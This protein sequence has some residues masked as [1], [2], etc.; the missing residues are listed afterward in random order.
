MAMVGID[1][2]DMPHM[3]IFYRCLG[4]DR[5]SVHWC[6]TFTDS[7]GHSARKSSELLKMDF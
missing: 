1:L 2:Y 3:T 6:P 5:L 4:E 7:T